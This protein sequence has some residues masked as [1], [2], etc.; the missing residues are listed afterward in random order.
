VIGVVVIV[1]LTFY[2]VWSNVLLNSMT[3]ERRLSNGASLFVV[4]SLWG[5]VAT[6]VGRD[7]VED[8]YA[9]KKTV[10]DW[11]SGAI[12]QVVFMTGGLLALLSIFAQWTY[13]VI[14]PQYGGG[15]APLVRVTIRASGG[16]SRLEEL[17]QQNVALVSKNDD[18]VFF[19][20]CDSASANRPRTVAVAKD[21][22]DV[23]EFLIDRSR[24]HGGE[25]Q[26]V[27]LDRSA[28]AKI[29]RGPSASM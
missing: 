22:I 6:S 19:L 5:V 21:A 27:A 18:M 25:N 7:Y 11:L 28:C 20:V 4:A 24:V 10:V 1:Q 16:V 14:A 15:A 29:A 8:W 3:V 2:V 13:P 17:S 23:V 12:V 26:L 9:R